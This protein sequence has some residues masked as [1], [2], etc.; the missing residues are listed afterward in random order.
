MEPHEV[1]VTVSHYSVDQLFT[2]GL[3]PLLLQHVHP[4]LEWEGNKAILATLGPRGFLPSV[5]DKIKRDLPP[6]RMFVLGMLRKIINVRSKGTFRYVIFFI[7][8]CCYFLEILKSEDLLEG[9]YITLSSILKI[10][11][12]S[13]KLGSPCL[14][15]SLSFPQ[16]P[17]KSLLQTVPQENRKEIRVTVDGSHSHG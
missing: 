16:P 13:P 14:S 4:P 9:G 7:L 2:L 8:D 15:S 11:T 6:H 12:C 10:L 17:T 5:G 1:K 3:W